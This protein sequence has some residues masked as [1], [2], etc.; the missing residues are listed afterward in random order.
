MRTRTRSAGFV[1]PAFLIPAGAALDDGDDAGTDHDD[2]NAQ[3]ATGGANGSDDEAS[4]SSADDA[5]TAGEDGEDGNVRDP[6]VKALSDENAKWR[7]RVRD[8]EGELAD[9]EVTRADVHDL[10]VEKEFYR[11]A[12]GRVADLGA[13]FK[14]AD[15]KGIAPNEDGSITGVEEMVNKVIQHYPFLAADYEDTPTQRTTKVPDGPKEG[16]SATNRRK[17][18]KPITTTSTLRKKFPA[19]ERMR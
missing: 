13:A 5:G 9:R 14:L 10:I 17:T 4:G 1:H 19:L 7:R 11:F 2:E 6:R 3:G 16:G 12:A 15:R 8:L 18:G